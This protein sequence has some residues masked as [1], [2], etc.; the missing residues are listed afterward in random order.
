[1]TLYL[2]PNLLLEA[3]DASL[4]LPASVKEAVSKLDGLIAESE[5]EGRRYLRRFVD[6]NRMAATPIRLLN[7][8]TKPDECNE[9]LN[10]ILKGE[11]WG[12]VSDAGLPCIAD[13]GSALVLLAHQKKLR[14]EVFAGPSSILMALQLSGLSGQRFAFHGY[15]P[16]EEPNLV[17]ALKQIESRSKQENSSQIWIEAPYRSAKIARS[18]FEILQPSTLFCIALDL[19]SESQTVRTQAIHRWRKETFEPGKRPAVF[20]L[21]AR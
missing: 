13:P 8:H 2:L 9:L 14:V 4:F 3:G 5:K 12:V 10:P 1:M 16:R 6:H 15:L 19:S 18:A 20:L 7:E 17:R 11:T 21:E